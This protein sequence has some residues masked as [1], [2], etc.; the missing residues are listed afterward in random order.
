MLLLVHQSV[1]LLAV[2]EHTIRSINLVLQFVRMLHAWCVS[3]DTCPSVSWY[4]L[5]SVCTLSLQS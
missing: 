1:R 5:M 4:L 3:T 2:P